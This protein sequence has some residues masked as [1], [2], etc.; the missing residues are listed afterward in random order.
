MSQD[1]FPL[2]NHKEYKYLFT[3]FTP[4]YNR[5]H[6]LHRV[7]ESLASQTFMDFE[8][9]IVDDGSSDETKDQVEKWQKENL[10]P[11]KYIY[12][13]NQGKHI[14]SNRGV[15]EA[16]GELFLTLDSDDACVAV[17]L[18]R[19][20]YHW[21]SIPLEQK[22]GFSAVTCLC[23]D[24]NGNI[25]GSKFPFEPTDSDSLEIRYR[26]KV[27]GEKWGFQTTKVMKKFP[28]PEVSGCSHV[29]ED[30]VWSAI[31]RKYK[32]RFVNESL[33][34]YWTGQDQVTKQ[35]VSAHFIS[36][37]SSSQ[38]LYHQEVL[39]KELSYFKIAPIHFIKSAIHFARFSFHAK[40]GMSTQFNSLDVFGGKILWLLTCLIGYSV[41]IKDSLKSK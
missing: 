12:Q 5:A 38:A 18:E 13:D 2:N 22:S 20:K 14:A 26:F 16:K 36:K 33:R 34:I 9:L 17:A 31:S 6:T 39:N 7:Y 23:Q 24:E 30:I 25:V 40:Q 32:T 15:T 8:W 11:L 21:D 28:F 1:N 35:K 37:V 3:V 41:Y 10:F 4:T 19:F 29:P 27:K